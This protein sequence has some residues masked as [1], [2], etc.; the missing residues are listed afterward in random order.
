MIRILERQGNY[1]SMYV[2]NI[3]KYKEYIHCILRKLIPEK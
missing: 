1:K 2:E 3:R